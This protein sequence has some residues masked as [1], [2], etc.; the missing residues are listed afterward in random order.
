MAGAAIIVITGRNQER[1]AQ[2]AAELK[3]VSPKS[4][5]ASFISEAASEADTTQL[6]TRVK[7]EVGI[8]DVLICN[9]GVFS[10][11]EEF[12]TTGTIDPA[13]WWSDMVCRCPITVSRV[14]YSQPST[15]D[16]PNHHHVGNQHTRSIPADIQFS[17]ATHLQRKGTYWYSYNHEFCRCFFQPAGHVSLRDQQV[18]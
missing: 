10:E 9:A 5:V 11:R 15:C 16:P 18:G 1:L 3:E 14:Y 4:K 12:P 13:V 7:A 6:W 2:V 17:A 8:I